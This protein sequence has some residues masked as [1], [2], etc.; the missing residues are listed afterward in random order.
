MIDVTPNPIAIQLGPIPVFWYGVTYAVGLGV[1]MAVLTKQARRF[2]Q[3][4]TLIF[5]G[6]VVVALAALIGGR[7]YHV[8]DQWSLYQGDLLKIV[9][10]PYSG[11]GVYGGLITGTLAALF[12]IR[13][14]KLSLPVWADIVAPALFTMQAVGRWGNF[15]NQELYGPPTSLPWGIAIDCAHRVGAYPCDAYPLATTHFQPLFLYESVSGLVGAAVL[16]W[17][18]SRPRRWLRPGDLLL[19]FFIWYAVVRFLLENLRTGNWRFEGIPT[20]QII[21]IAFAVVA[22]AILVWRHRTTPPVE[23]LPMA[24]EG[25]VAPPAPSASEPPAVQPDPDPLT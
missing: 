8:I 1:A 25:S 7:L 12:L 16:L 10:P 21:S 6:L 2:G 4:T 24:A 23:P 5:N 13:R 14:W 15:F 11:L 22:L 18:S 19:I 9:L 3:D 17:L 20:A